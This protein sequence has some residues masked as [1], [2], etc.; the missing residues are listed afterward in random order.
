MS[1]QPPK[2]YRERRPWGEFIKFVENSPCTVKIITVNHGEGFSLQYHKSRDEFWH[3]LDGNGTATIGP[4]RI[5][6]AKGED[7]FIPSGTLHRIEA[8]D[9]DVV[10][11]EISFGAFD[12]DDIVRVEDKYDR[13][14]KT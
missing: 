11:L 8:V 5:D 6:I 2:P 1:T 7:Y 3:I 13:V 10:L 12:E 14:K 4:E 9:K